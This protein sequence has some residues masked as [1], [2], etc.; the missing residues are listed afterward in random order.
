MILYE[1]GI[2]NAEQTLEA[3]KIR[4]LYSQFVFKTEEALSFLKFFESFDPGGF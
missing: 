3:L 1:Q 4:A 2:L